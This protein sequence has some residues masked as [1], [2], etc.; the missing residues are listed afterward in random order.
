MAVMVV[1]AV[2]QQPFVCAGWV[3][4][5]R[6]TW[7]FYSEL[8]LVYSR[9]LSVFFCECVIERWILVWYLP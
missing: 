4:I 5:L 1:Q 9:W 6:Q 7:V 3:Q 8:L 2:E